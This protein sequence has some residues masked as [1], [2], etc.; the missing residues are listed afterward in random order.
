MPSD[1]SSS[2][3]PA[4]GDDTMLTTILSTELAGLLVLRDNLP[5]P[6]GAC[7][8]CRDGSKGHQVSNILDKEDENRFQSFKRAGYLPDPLNKLDDI[9]NFLWTCPSC[10][11]LF[12][13]PFPT[14][15]ILPREL[16]FFNLWEHRDFERRNYEARSGATVSPRTVPEHDDYNGKCKFYVLTDDPT[17]LPG[18]LRERVE[19]GDTGLYTEASPTALILH[20]GRAMGIPMPCP[21]KYGL[22]K[23]LRKKLFELFILWERPS[24]AN[25]PPMS[26]NEAA[27]LL[28]ESECAS[29]SPVKKAG[30]RVRSWSSGTDSSGNS[31]SV[32]S[33]TRT[34]K[35]KRVKMKELTK[36][37]DKER[38]KAEMEGLEYTSPASPEK[39][40]ISSRLSRSLLPAP[41]RPLKFGGGKKMTRKKMGTRVNDT[42]D[43]REEDEDGD[44]ESK[45]EDEEESESNDRDEDGDGQDE[46]SDVD[47]DWDFGP[48][49]SSS[50]IIK[51]AVKRASRC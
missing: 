31:N 4:V 45:K 9:E 25:G 13:N 29:P 41:L 39:W 33:T 3:A 30:K 32:K 21:I 47:E 51:T 46:Y 44:S 50:A 19:N 16:E 28:R 40:R 26:S 24:P 1:T 6:D 38:K 27:E 12:D 10:A 43:D 22:P 23:E 7:T 14:I 15:V 11:E 48:Q 49:M 18:K 37:D 17:T 34:P 5:K 42:S 20:A 36:G 2:H 8:I 35:S